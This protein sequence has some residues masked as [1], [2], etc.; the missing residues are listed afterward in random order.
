MS[1]WDIRRTASCC[2]FLEGKGM[3]AS[4]LTVA[5][6]YSEFSDKV[7]RG[8]LYLEDLLFRFQIWCFFRKLYLDNQ[9]FL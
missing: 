2:S 8:G 9:R 3:V 4:L 7:K 1:F 5:A 6:K